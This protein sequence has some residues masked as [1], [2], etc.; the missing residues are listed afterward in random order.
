MRKM[1]TEVNGDE[2]NRYRTRFCAM[3]TA[4]TFD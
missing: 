3:G 2:E 4:L 1:G